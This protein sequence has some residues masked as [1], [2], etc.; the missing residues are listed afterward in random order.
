MESGSI[1][2]VQSTDLERPCTGRPLRLALADNLAEACSDPI[3]DVHSFYT[4]VIDGQI[5]KTIGSLQYR[6]TCHP[7]SK[8]SGGLCRY[9][10]I[11]DQFNL[12]FN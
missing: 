11:L 5:N 3:A 10:R 2:S 6:Q 12:V 1:A 8:R 7:L 4:H 9:V